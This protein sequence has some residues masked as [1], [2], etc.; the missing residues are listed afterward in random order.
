M[1]KLLLGGLIFLI[2]CQANNSQSQIQRQLKKVMTDFLYKSV[3]Y[4]SSKVKYH[5]L[6][7][8]YYEDKMNYECEFTVHMIQSG[9]DTTGSM[10]AYISKDFK[11]VNRN[12]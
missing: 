8:I 1:K 6:D 2:S 9:H 4:D 5:V 10:R 3:N 12:Y 7:V 11:T